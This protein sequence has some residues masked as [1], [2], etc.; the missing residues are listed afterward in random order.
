MKSFALSGKDIAF[1]FYLDDLIIDR[2]RTLFSTLIGSYEFDLDYGI[3]YL[4]IFDKSSNDAIIKNHIKK[5]VE[6]YLDLKVS[7]DSFNRKDKTLE[8]NMKMRMTGQEQVVDVTLSSVE[9]KG[10]SFVFNLI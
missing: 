3:D 6:R 5:Q 4:L 10:I 9:D 7:F 8:I 2:A 1:P